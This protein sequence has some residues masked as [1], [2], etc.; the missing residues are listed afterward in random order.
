[1]EQ[2]G[3]HQPVIKGSVNFCLPVE[4]SDL[5]FI[6]AGFWSFQWSRENAI[7]ISVGF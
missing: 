1:M 2:D 6:K 3:E 4:K 7:P 5:S